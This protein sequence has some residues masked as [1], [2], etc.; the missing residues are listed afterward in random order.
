MTHLTDEDMVLH[1]YDEDAAA[2]EIAGHLAAC[3]RCREQYARLQQTLGAIA[4]SPVPLRDE[5]YGRQVWARIR[6]HIEAIGAPSRSRW[7]LG[8]FLSWP[9]LALAGGLAVLV[10]AAFLA[11]RAWQTPPA[12]PAAN[13]AAGALQGQDRILMVAVGQH[14]E[15][16]ARTLVEIEN[17]PISAS[18]DISVEQTRA[19]DLIAASRLYRQAAVRAGEGGLASVLEDV[20]RVFAEFTNYPSPVSRSDMNLIRARLDDTG[21]LFK[22]RVAETQVRQ[23]QL[24]SAHSAGPRLTQT[25]VG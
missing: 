16:S 1:Y 17:Q 19:E 3:A 15:R 23:R 18:T 25:K 4:G 13:V 14:L 2:A 21:L 10:V 7:A 5:S 8:S 12:A 11:G 22:V 6:P 20:E 24:D 9:R